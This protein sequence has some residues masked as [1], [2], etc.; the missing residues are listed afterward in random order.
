MVFVWRLNYTIKN[1][2]LYF[3]F[4]KVVNWCI[5]VETNKNV[6]LFPWTGEIQAVIWIAECI[7]IFL[8]QNL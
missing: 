6:E 3:I 8:L 4:Q 5:I 7:K 2:G 1:M